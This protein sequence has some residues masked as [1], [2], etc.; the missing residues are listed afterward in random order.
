MP[1]TDFE[2]TRFWI[3]IE[4]AADFVLRMMTN[5]VGGEMYVPKIPSMKIVDL[6]RIIGPECELKEVGIRP[7]EK[8]HEILIPRD[9]ARLTLEFDDHFVIQPAIG[10]IFDKHKEE[11]KIGKKVDNRFEFTSETNTWLL[12][13][14]ELRG[15]VK[16]MAESKN[17]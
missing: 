8:L 5:M 4:Q 2:M 7:G 3:T 12:T 15:Y 6:A 11:F 14:D 10:W 1:I 17:E 9:E 16:E 13:E